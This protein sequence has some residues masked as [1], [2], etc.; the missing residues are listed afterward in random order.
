MS[1]IFDNNNELQE[2]LEGFRA[3]TAR[4]LVETF[5]L[6]PKHRAGIEASQIVPGGGVELHYPDFHEVLAFS[7]RKHASN[8]GVFCDSEVSQ[9]GV[10]LRIRYL[11]IDQLSIREDEARAFKQLVDDEILQ[12]LMKLLKEALNAN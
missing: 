12:N 6:N 1:E 8:W 10:V 7:L 11:E 3:E 2:L 4:V 9:K 5:G